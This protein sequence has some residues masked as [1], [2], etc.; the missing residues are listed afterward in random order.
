MSFDWKKTIGSV[1]PGIASMLGGPLA[2]TATSALLGFFDID[3]TSNDADIQLEQAIKAMTPAQMVELK[4]VENKLKIDLKKADINMFKTEVDDRKS[5]RKMNTDN[6]DFTPSILA[7][8]IVGA[9]G[10]ISYII[11]TATSELSNANIVVRSMGTLD[12]ALMA[13]LYFYFGS[14][15]GSRKK[16]PK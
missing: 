9:W 8:L 7:A 3:S 16:D 11:F 5:A 12:A 4:K 1:V 6:K 13:V 10:V 15:A 14:S 2:G